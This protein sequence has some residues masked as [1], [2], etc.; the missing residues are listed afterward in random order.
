MLSV[1]NLTEMNFIKPPSFLRGRQSD[2]LHCASPCTLQNLTSV[3]WTLRTQKL[4]HKDVL[5]AEVSIRNALLSVIAQH[6]F[7]SFA[8]SPDAIGPPIFPEHGDVFLYQL[9]EP[10]K[11]RVH[12]VEDKA[13]P[14]FVFRSF[15][16]IAEA[17]VD[18]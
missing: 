5:Y 1:I 17:L 14:V 10:G 2:N 7:E 18:P 3:A 16:G 9:A 8:I 15:L 13:E 6:R 12:V 4:G 11:H